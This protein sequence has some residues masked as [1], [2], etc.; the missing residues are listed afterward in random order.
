MI[1]TTS[2]HPSKL[3][4]SIIRGGSA[5]MY[6]VAPKFSRPNRGRA[7]SELSSLSCSRI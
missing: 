6:F 4:E 3:S 2:S 5:N 7:D 1:F